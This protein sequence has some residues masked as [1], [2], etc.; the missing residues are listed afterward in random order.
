MKS[1]ETYAA[2]LIEEL[3]AAEQALQQARQ[4]VPGLEPIAAGLAVQRSTIVCCS[5]ADGGALSPAISWQDRRNAAWLE[6]LG[7]Q[8]GRV[9][10]LTGLPLS[11]HYGASKIRWCLEVRAVFGRNLVFVE[12]HPLTVV[13]E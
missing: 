2:P 11:P 12:E 9:R 10:E 13:P 7:N 1:L 8:A 4:N 5:R 3:A 6:T